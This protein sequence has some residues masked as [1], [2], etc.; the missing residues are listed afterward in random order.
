MLC[1]KGDRKAKQR[2][3]HASGLSYKHVACHGPENHFSTNQMVQP[4]SPNA[5]ERPARRIAEALFTQNRRTSN[6]CGA[7]RPNHPPD[8]FAVLS[9]QF[10]PAEPSR[11]PKPNKHMDNQNTT[12]R[13][14]VNRIRMLVLR[15][16]V[17]E[18]AR[19]MPANSYTRFETAQ[20][21]SPSTPS[22]GYGNA[23]GGSSTSRAL[24]RH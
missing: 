18:G 6:G 13:Q 15:R 19:R 10:Y 23:G 21:S 22:E 14:T 20:N 8:A 16:V 3:F 5:G 17:S 1:Q 11:A 2:G 4:K 12:P 9:A 24:F 7:T